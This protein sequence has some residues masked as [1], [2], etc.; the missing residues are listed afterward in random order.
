MTDKY[1]EVLEVAK[2]LP[3]DMVLTLEKTLQGYFEE[4]GVPYNAD[5]LKAAREFGNMIYAGLPPVYGQVVG[6]ML[7]T[8][9]RIIHEKETGL[10]T[11]PVQPK[12]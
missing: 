6:T 12:L 4:A 8:L 9:T 3:A 11:S 10:L 7:L 2:N 1:T 5:T